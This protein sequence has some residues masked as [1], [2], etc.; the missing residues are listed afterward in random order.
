MS[1]NKLAATRCN[2][3]LTKFDRVRVYA[4]QI[5]PQPLQAV[6]EATLTFMTNELNLGGE[7]S[8]H[9]KQLC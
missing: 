5:I 4:K 9:L 7:L 2:F 8:I 3:S 6:Y 1:A